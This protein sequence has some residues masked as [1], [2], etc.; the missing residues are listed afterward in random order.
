MYSYTR[1]NTLHYI[2]S[3]CV[4]LHHVT[5][6]YVLFHFIPV[7]FI[8]LHVTSMGVSKRQTITVW[9]II[10]RFPAIFYLLRGCYMISKKY[11]YILYIYTYT[12]IHIHI[13]EASWHNETTYMSQGRWHKNCWDRHWLLMQPANSLEVDD[14]AARR[15]ERDGLYGNETNMNHKPMGI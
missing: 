11:I 9:F 1:Y 5:L 2:T 14:F 12:Y 7:H 13:R 4:P 3:H 15:S 8:S 10:S 6:R